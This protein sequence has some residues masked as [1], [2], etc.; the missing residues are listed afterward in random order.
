ME[1]VEEISVR[2]RF[3]KKIKSSLMSF[4]HVE[5]D[6]SKPDNGIKVIDGLLIDKYLLM[7]PE[8]DIEHS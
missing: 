7:L 8:I 3:A 2:L 4:H 5:F 1:I 6:F